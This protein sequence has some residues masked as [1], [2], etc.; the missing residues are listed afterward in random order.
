[1]IDYAIFLVLVSIACSNLQFDEEIK[2][3]YSGILLF[4]SLM[5][6]IIS[7]WMGGEL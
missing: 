3:M 6:F 2:N 1:M 7:I 4:I 5:L